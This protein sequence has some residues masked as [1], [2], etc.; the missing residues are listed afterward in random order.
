MSTS[1]KGAP[2]E[3]LLPV[4]RSLNL[5]WWENVRDA[6]RLCHFSCTQPDADDSRILQPLRLQQHV[7][8]LRLQAAPHGIL[9]A[10]LFLNHQLGQRFFQREGSLLAG[11]GDL[12]LQVLQSVLPDMLP[13]AVPDD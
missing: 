7:Q 2:G 3:A 9:T 6:S 8:I 12:L 11:D 13:S 10:Q 5:R 1:L 4:D